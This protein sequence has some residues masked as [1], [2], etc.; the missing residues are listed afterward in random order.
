MACIPVDGA[1]ERGRRGPERILE[2]PHSDFMPYLMPKP[3][4]PQ[5][6]LKTILGPVLLLQGLWVRLR[7]PILPEP[8]GPRVGRTGSGPL[9]RLLVT[10]DSS[11]AGVGAASQSEALLG[12]LTQEL[13][14]FYTVACQLVAH[15]GATTRDTLTVLA[16]MAVQPFD[17]VVTAIGVNDLTTQRRQNE[18]LADQ[19]RLIDL[20]RAKFKPRVILVSG[21]PPVHRFPALPPA[22]ALAPGYR[23]PGVQCGP[24]RVG[25]Q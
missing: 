13:K 21:L 10:G 9:L 20:L 8:D 18:F 15:T 3:F 23:C 4:M 2:G 16:D 7:T 6:L 19:Q 17:V 14:P 25:A 5:A 22:A 1:N 24:G 11:A 12:C